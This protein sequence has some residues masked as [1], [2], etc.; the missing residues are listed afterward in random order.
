MVK[1]G[2]YGENDKLVE[3][4]I[5][6]LSREKQL[7][8]IRIVGADIKVLLEEKKKID[9]EYYRYMLSELLKEPVFQ[10][11]DIWEGDMK[12]WVENRLLQ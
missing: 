9:A 2:S 7:E 12:Q 3:K 8:L 6:N 11:E 4:V 1:F 5:H 10:N